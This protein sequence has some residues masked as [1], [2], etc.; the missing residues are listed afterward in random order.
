MSKSD[1]LGWIKAQ[2]Q[3]PDIV[4]EDTIPDKIISLTNTKIESEL[5]RFQIPPDE[6][7]ENEILTQ[8]AFCMAISLCSRARIITKTSGAIASEKF[9]KVLNKYHSTNPLFFF[10][11]GRSRA[12]QDLLPQETLR[13]HFYA[14]LRGYVQLWFYQ[15]HGRMMP[16][17]KLAVDK[18]SRGFG[19]NEP[20]DSFTEADSET[21]EYF[22]EDSDYR[23]HR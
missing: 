7:E 1:L 5:I 15:K 18:T 9:G 3:N 22:I 2:F 16:K 10:A 19:W 6:I 23:Y 20:V 17:P 8:A 14:L 4:T 13:M 11:T 12:F 21:G